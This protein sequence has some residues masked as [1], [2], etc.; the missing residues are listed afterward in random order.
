MLKSIRK[1]Y[2]YFYSN[3]NS[4]LILLVTMSMFIIITTA[5]YTL[6]VSSK[7]VLQGEVSEPQIHLL[8]MGM[9]AVNNSVNTADQIGVNILLSN[10]TYQFLN[11]AY[12]MQ[13]TEIA[14]LVEYLDNLAVSPAVEGVMIYDNVRQ[15]IV[16]ST[17]YGFSS[18]LS[19]FFDT[20]WQNY[21]ADLNPKHFTIVNRTKSSQFG[22]EQKVET[23]TLFR[24][25]VRENTLAGVIMVNM[26]KK[27]LFNKIFENYTSQTDASR[28]VIDDS[29]H[30][31]Y[32]TNNR[33]LSQEQIASVLSQ[34]N[35]MYFD[36]SDGKENYLI[37][38][39]SSDITGWK[40]VSIITQQ[41]LLQKVITIRNAVFGLSII[42]IIAGV[43]G[44]IITHHIT[45]K[46][47]RRI[48]HL[49]L[50][51]QPHPKNME[52]RDLEDY[53]LKLT[54]DL[55]D[56]SSLV[57]HN[58]SELH[59]KYIQDLI[60]GR[61]SSWEMKDRWHRHFTDWTDLPLFTLLISIDKY[62]QWASS[63]NEE[64]QNLLW[65]SIKNVCEEWMGRHW[66]F[67]FVE[68]DLNL[69][70]IVQ[71][72]DER[73][74]IQ[75]LREDLSGLVQ[76]IQKM[77]H[78]EVSAAVSEEFSDYAHLRK[79]CLHAEL[80]L[81]Y[82]LY[83]DYSNVIL[84]S[85]LEE[86]ADNKSIDP[87][88]KKDLLT[89]LEG[90]NG[91]IAIK[92]LDALKQFMKDSFVSPAEAI[93][94]FQQLMDSLISY[95]GDHG[96]AKPGIL[97][98]Y[99]SFWFNTMNLDDIIH[100][101]IQV[102]QESSQ[103]SD[104]RTNSREFL[105]VQQMI[106]YMKQHLHENIGVPEIADSVGLSK[107]SVNNIFKQ[108]MNRT[109]YDYLTELRMHEV[110]AQLAGTDMKIADIALKVGYQNENSLIRAFRKHRSIT[111]GQ[112][113]EMCRNK[114]EDSGH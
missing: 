60:A 1:W 102:Y 104:Q 2:N 52:N 28:F 46:P 59:A 83:T 53:L 54:T 87:L 25:V 17:P 98:R 15:R 88:W 40:F 82:R 105:I 113:R 33:V 106:H 43:I 5:G 94:F 79:S 72:T 36:F 51:G 9:D 77:I 22:S 3:R 75:Q 91:E 63:Y 80:A 61:M 21:V 48:R 10:L 6:Y 13:Q 101:F 69:L 37:S 16:G 107:S 20:D 74:N 109:L 103:L 56:V 100:F 23:I 81:S 39:V 30:I 55:A 65:F 58:R 8:R 97:R 41:R 31:I 32:E 78:I 71:K 29:N 114:N 11:P 18:R 111:P 14:H 64:D 35:N 62:Y 84:F 99:N 27:K 38:Q 76:T 34:N 57:Q 73:Q 12:E 96:L 108:E 110:E 42:S 67:A 44:I 85:E 89:C 24:P 70:L 50:A 92:L 47:V 68:R 4:R 49:L 95:F 19:N 86:P 112:F 26:N 66:R 90:G 45:F 7:S 93:Y